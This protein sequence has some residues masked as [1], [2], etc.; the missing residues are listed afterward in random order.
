MELTTLKDAVDKANV[1]TSVIVL[2]GAMTDDQYSLLYNN[3]EFENWDD[4]DN[5]GPM[6]HLCE[7]EILPCEYF[8][9]DEET[10]YA[11]LWKTEVKDSCKEEDF[12]VLQCWLCFN[13]FHRK[14]CTL[15]M[16]DEFYLT[17]KSSKNWVCPPC[18]PEFKMCNKTKKS[19][20]KPTISTVN[21]LLIAIF[22][23]LYQ[24][25]KYQPSNIVIPDVISNFEMYCVSLV[26]KVVLDYTSNFEV[27]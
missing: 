15:S 13:Y 11:V 1:N 18:V 9:I 17:V 23:C 16:T 4:D 22:K 10:R 14:T 6:C 25:L 2:D 20:K 21:N 26:R 7:Q 12:G 19:T 8:L 24:D 27:G 3:L 5:M